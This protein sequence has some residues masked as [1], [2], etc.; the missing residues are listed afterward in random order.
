MSQEDFND[1]MNNADFYQIEDP[2]S[3]M[4]HQHEDKSSL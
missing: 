4:S 3:N 1:Y 2:K